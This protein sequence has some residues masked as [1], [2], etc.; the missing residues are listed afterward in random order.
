LRSAETDGLRVYADTSA[1]GPVTGNRVLL[2]RMVSNV[3]DNAV[4]HNVPGG[5]IRVA[6]TGRSMVVAN[7]GPV[8]DLASLPGWAARSNG[9]PPTAPRPR[10]VD[11]ARHRDRPRRHGVPL[12]RTRRRPPGRDHAAMRVLVVEDAAPLAEVIAE[13]LRDQGMAV[14]VAADGLTAF[15]KLDV[16]APTTW[17]SSTATSP[18]CTATPSAR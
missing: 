17:S 18:A 5:W 11:R 13:G 4:V 2:A 8:L 6:V 14:D 3:I 16:N 12:G 9:W 1:A 10:P 7:S 15:D